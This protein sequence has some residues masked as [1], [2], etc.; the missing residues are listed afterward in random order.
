MILR[1]TGPRSVEGLPGFEVE[2]H[3]RHYLFS[4]EADRVLRVSAELSSGP[5]VS[6]LLYDEPG[7]AYWQPPHRGEP[8]T[9]AEM[10]PILVRITA[11]VLL[12]GVRPIW[13][14]IPPEAERTDWPVILSEAQALLRRARQ[15]PCHHAGGFAPW[16]GQLRPMD[17]CVLPR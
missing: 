16:A 5:D 17:Q 15:P 13:Q 1:R 14:T 4:R 10:H 8:L 6:I 3:F 12:L 11:A 7:H 2:E 9:R